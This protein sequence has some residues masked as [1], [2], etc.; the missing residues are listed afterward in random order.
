MKMLIKIKISIMILT[1]KKIYKILIPLIKILVIL[2]FKT[3]TII[4]IKM[5]C[6]NLKIIIIYMQIK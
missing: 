6:Y 2:I 4:T 3:K 5:I 1:F